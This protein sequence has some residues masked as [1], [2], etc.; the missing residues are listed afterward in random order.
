MKTCPAC[1]QSYPTHFMVCPQDGRTLVESGAWADGTVVR[2]KYRILGQIGA[3]GMA[4]VYKAEHLHFGE[5]RALKAI[6]PELAR[7]ETFVLRFVREAVLTRR[8]KHP[9]AVHVEDIDRTEDGRPFIVMEFIEGR[10]LKDAIQLEAPMSVARVCGITR[11]I[12]AAL[13]A[14][15]T[16]GLIHRDIKPANVLLAESTSESGVR[17][18][19][20]KVLDFG[21]AKVKEGQIEDSKLRQLTLTGTGM[22]IGTPAY[23]SPEQAMGK[24]GDELDG[25]SDIYS[26][27]VVMYQMLVGELPLKADSGFGLMMAHISTPPTPLLSVRSDV[28]AE[29]AGLVMSCLAKA[30]EQRPA[31]ARAIIE[32]IEHWESEPARRAAERLKQ[33]QE[34][35]ERER[36]ELERVAR[37]QQERQRQEREAAEAERLRAQLEQLARERA[38]VERLGREAVERERISREL[39]EQERLARARAEEDRKVRELM[40]ANRL[41]R[42]QAEAERLAKEKAEAEE[43]AR[44]AARRERLS[45]ERAEKERLERER[46]EETR[47]AREREEAARAARLQAEAGRLTREKE[48]AERMASDEA[49]RARLAQERAE[50]E[51]LAREKIEAELRAAHKMPPIPVPAETLGLDRGSPG[52]PK[53]SEPETIAGLGPAPMEIATSISN[54]L[55]GFGRS[56]TLATDVDQLAALETGGAITERAPVPR[57]PIRIDTGSSKPANSEA[58]TESALRPAVPQRR[59][60]LNATAARLP[61]AQPAAPTFPPEPK[62]LNRVHGWLAGAAA[63]LIVLGGLVVWRMRSQRA[64][65][66]ATPVQPQAARPA[67]PATNQPSDDSPAVGKDIPAQPAATPSQDSRQKGSVTPSASTSGESAAESVNAA[68]AKVRFEALI[69][70]GDGDRDQGQ[71]DQAIAAYTKASGLKVDSASKKLVQDRIKIAQDNKAAEQ[72]AGTLGH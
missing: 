15:H 48:A 24:K 25:R 66:S 6:N 47:R 5:I 40:E 23:M 37:E 38:E 36:R 60:P 46:A 72:Q 17:F 31:S 55:E 3:G 61:E 54:G 62:T 32:A 14:A 12:A 29:I 22:L 4:T 68:D 21:I 58:R 35:R 13:Q 52:T 59:E 10:S 8:L 39:A 7:D 11:Q 19:A 57:S 41:L 26:L 44:E 27:G 9:N 16:L 69:K 33:E 67:T 20:A 2:E 56:A 43:L 28:P 30:R 34:R 42:I 53:L 71:Y 64:S 51:R 65:P 49:K 1:R 45:Q 63:I 50:R 18:E 70:E